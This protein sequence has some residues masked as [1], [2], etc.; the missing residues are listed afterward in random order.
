MRKIL[1]AAARVTAIL[2]GLT[3][4]FC[5]LLF[6]S[7][8]GG[9]GI[10]SRVQQHLK[11]SIPQFEKE[12]SQPNLL[13]LKN[14]FYTL[15]NFTETTILQEALFMN[16]AANPISIFENPRVSMKN[17]HDGT[18]VKIVSFTAAVN[19]AQSNS[20]Y[21][22]YWMGFRAIVRP[23]LIFMNYPNIRLLLSIGF[24]LLLA[25]ACFT[26]YHNTNIAVATAFLLSVLGINIAIASIELQFACCFDKVR[27]IV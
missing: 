26:I 23:L 19:G 4:L 13:Q 27:I 5:G 14:K 2:M 11:E 21:S 16:T 3:V 25:A 6:L 24:Y 10:Q 1:I 22:Y 12:G 18:D 17:T 15:D 20:N 7:G 9:N 8:L